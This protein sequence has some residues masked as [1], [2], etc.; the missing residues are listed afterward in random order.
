M[1]RMWPGRWLGRARFG[2]RGLLRVLLPALALAGS[3]ALA[4]PGAP[5]YSRPRAWA[6]LP[7]RPNP[8]MTVPDPA[9]TD[10]QGDAAADVFYI[11]PTIYAGLWSLNAS[12]ED[13]GYRRDV[14]TYL[15]PLQASSLN[16]SGRIYAPYYRQ[17]SIW[18]YLRSQSGQ[19][20]TFDTAYADVKAA[21]LYYLEQYNRGRPLII[22]SHSQGT[23]MAVRLLEEL[24]RA[25]GLERI[26]VVAYLIG[27]RIGA[28]QI[29]GLAPC[30]SAAQT[31][32][33][34][35]WATVAMGAE[36]E[37]L[38]GEPRGRPVC[39][40]PLSWRMDEAF[41]PARRH[42]GGVPDSFDRIEPGLVG[43]RCRGG[44]LEIAPPPS[45]YAHAGGDYHESD[46]NLFYLDIRRNAQMRLRAFGAGR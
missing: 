23:Q 42:L 19:R 27:E 11:Y 44:L 37:L 20:R 31:G 32:C 3:A 13:P 10:R 18:A 45:G 24:Y 30:R 22:L 5:D 21:F 4:A 46:I 15:L 12:V 9:L 38:T 17:A 2:R 40:N 28:E 25:R 7:D 39:V 33:F 41:V 16:S 35:T 6:A 36:P 8:S 14:A 29:P 1:R 34:V 26:L 43:A